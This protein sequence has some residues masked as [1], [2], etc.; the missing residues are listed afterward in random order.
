MMWNP[1]NSTRKNPNLKATKPTLQ[2]IAEFPP[3]P[4]SEKS[5]PPGEGQPVFWRGVSPFK[6]H[7]V[8]GGNSWT[9]GAEQGHLLWEVPSVEEADAWHGRPRGD[10]KNTW[11]L[12]LAGE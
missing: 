4:G 2:V 6:W 7:A 9:Y 1:E 8:W 10:D 12:K 3:T 11:T 5:D